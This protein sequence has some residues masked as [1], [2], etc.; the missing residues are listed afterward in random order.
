MNFRFFTGAAID[1]IGVK[2]GIVNPASLIN[3]S[4]LEKVESIPLSCVYQNTFRM[5]Q[6]KKQGMAK[7]K[8]PAALREEVWRH[9]MGEA[10]KA[11]CCVTWCT[12]QI[13]AF[14]FAVG[15]NVP[16]SKGGSLTLSNLRPICSR[17]NSSMG[18]NYTIDE[19]NQL[20][21]APPSFWARLCC[22]ATVDVSPV[23]IV[24]IV[25]KPMLKARLSA[26]PS[27]PSTK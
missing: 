24:G 11:K 15:H 23:V 22:C 19:W 27:S 3:A 5:A 14:D 18:A 26:P 8:I 13:T 25:N 21:V 4:K 9:W 2:E 6:P 20:A 17:C 1:S 12:N 10:F 16:E 7:A